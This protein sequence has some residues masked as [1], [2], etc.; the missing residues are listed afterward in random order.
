MYIEPQCKMHLSLPPFL[1][2]LPHLRHM[3][4]PRLGVKSELQMPAYTTAPATATSDPSCIF[5][6]RHS[7]WQCWILNP[8]SGARDQTHNLVHTSRVHFL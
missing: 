8:P 5:D 4:V 3:E 7:S 6:L 1:P 2:S